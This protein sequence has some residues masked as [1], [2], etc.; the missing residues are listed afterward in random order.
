MVKHIVFWTFHETAEGRS[1]EENI[2]LA[3]NGLEGLKNK[4]PS[5]RKLETGINI[6]HRDG[7]FDLAL[8]CEFENI[9]GLKEYQEHPEHIKIIQLLKNIRN[10]R[11]YIDYEI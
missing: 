4:I 9:S 7:A 2:Q 6:T 3:I 8:Y 10:K 11:V 5:V 1:K